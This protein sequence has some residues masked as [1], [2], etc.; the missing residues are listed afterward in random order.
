MILCSLEPPS[1]SIVLEEDM[2]SAWRL[3][4]DS[5]SAEMD[6]LRQMQNRFAGEL[7]FP[8]ALRN[9]TNVVPGSL[10]RDGRPQAVK[11]QLP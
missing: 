11:S 6:S 9:L 4:Q 3:M 7:S 10:N 2:L 8:Q 1:E 5:G